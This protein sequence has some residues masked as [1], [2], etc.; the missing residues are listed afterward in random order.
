[1][2]RLVQGINQAPKL[3]VLIYAREHSHKIWPSMVQYNYFSV[4]EFLLI[5]ERMI[6]IH[7]Y[8]TNVV[9]GG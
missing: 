4:S 2:A 1:M 7:H 8:I 9:V 6:E 3:D 5:N